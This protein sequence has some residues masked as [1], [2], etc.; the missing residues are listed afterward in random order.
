MKLTFKHIIKETIEDSPKIENMLFRLFNREFFKIWRDEDDDSFKTGFRFDNIADVL[1]Y[2]G[3]MVGLDYDV[4][5]YFFIK[6][7][8]DPKSNWN[9]EVGGDVFGEFQIDEFI[10]WREYSPIYDILKKLGWFNK[11]FNTGEINYND[12]KPIKLNY[13]DNMSFNDTEG[14]YPNMVLS[15]DGWDDFAEL[16]YDRDLAE[17]AF[18]ED[19]SEFFS[20]WDTPRD[21][22]ISDMTG[23]A[24]DKVIESIPAYTDKIMIG[25]QGLEDLYEMGMPE[26]VL[27]DD[28]DFL[29]INPTFINT[30]R[31]QIKNN[32]VDGEDVLEFLLSHNEL[33]ELERDMRSAYHST[34]NDVVENDIRER[35]VEEI[36]ELFG[37]KPEWV[38]NTKSG[39]SAKYNLKVP[40]STELIDKVLQHYIDTEGVFP[41]EQESYFI[42]VVKTLL[43]EESGL[44][45]LP[46]LDYYYP[47]TTKAKEWFE[48]SL[49]NYL[50]MSA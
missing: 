15:I 21:E 14:L 1:T 40:I 36:T 10:R 25:G 35:A 23:K 27:G 30:L 6:W 5:L 49:D 28:G 38:R 13:Y 7:T 2:F 43:D 29:D 9:H 47:D 24:M 41:E 19:F 16:F 33:G 4:V 22:I 26:E 42:D 48:E 45:E 8:L 39:D 34:I 44:L 31:T 50:E 3:E 20:Y 18:S 12:K 11:K 37:S 46:N 32:E 17:E